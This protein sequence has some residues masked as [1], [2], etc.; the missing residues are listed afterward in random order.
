MKS[1]SE[2]RAEWLDELLSTRAADRPRAEAAVRRLYSAAALPEPH[3]VVWFDSPAAAS[4]GA[5][6]LAAPYNFLWNQRLAS[7]SRTDNE[8]IERA[9]SALGGQTGLAAWPRVLAASGGPLGM[10]MQLPPVPSRSMHMKFLEAR[11][12]LTSDTGALFALPPQDDVLHNAEDWFRGSNR[13]ALRSA[14][15]CPTTDAIIG[16][17][18]FG[19]Y[20]F[21]AMADDEHRAVGRDAPAILAAAW[22]IAR[23]SGLWWPFEKIAI[24]SDRPAELHVNAARLLHREDG[25]AAVYRDGWSVYAWSG[26]AVPEKWIMQT[27][28]VPARE[29]KGFDPAFT[30]W[31]TARTKSAARAPKPAPAA[32]PSLLQ[33]YSAGAHREVW[34]EMIALGDRVRRAPYA[35]DAMAVAQETMRRA[36]TN[37]RTIVERLTN[38]G[39]RFADRP[40]GIHGN[41]QK[42]VATFEKAVATL[43]LSLHAFYAAVGQVNLIGTHPTLISP[44]SSVAEDPLVVYGL[45]E[46]AVEYDDDGEPEALIIAPDDLHKANESGGDPYE[47]AV[48]DARADGEVVNERH[49]LFFVDYLRLCFQ[50]GGFPGFDG[51]ESLPREIDVLRQGLLEL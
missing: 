8:Q 10:S 23:S 20:S 13:G 47:I 11:M 1:K 5:A 33:R 19:D 26:K 17:S 34:T 7:P 38:M 36:D 9:R 37:L 43:P 4:W 45:D 6:L 50:Y 28:T 15:H 35:D 44:R 2:I 21:S 32:G 14:L 41:A 42:Q 27:E 31:A 24:M 22:D 3:H 46:D 29:Y 25:P 39:Y 40:L 16:Q 49:G 12:S 51:Q 30:K 18:F 48:P